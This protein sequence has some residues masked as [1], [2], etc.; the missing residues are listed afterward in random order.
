MYIEDINKADLVAKLAQHR[1]DNAE[2]SELE[3]AYYERQYEKLD[4][5]GTEELL[6]CIEQEISDD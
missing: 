2:I 4:E 5:W 6:E 1:T 3:S